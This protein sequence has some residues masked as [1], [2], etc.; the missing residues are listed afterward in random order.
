MKID[1]IGA[2]IGGLT[3]AIAFQKKGFTVRIFEQAKFLT[4]AGA[5]I[6]LASNAMQVFKHLNLN[7]DIQ[8]A[9]QTISSMNITKPNLRRLS[10]VSLADFENTY[11]VKNTAI[12]RGDLQ[13]ILLN[14]IDK[15][16]I[17]L[18]HTLKSIM[19]LEN[20]Q[21]LIFENGEEILSNI[22]IGADGIH[23]TV[24]KS[25]V[26]KAK[27]RWANQVCWRGIVNY[28]LPDQY[29]NQLNEA[30]GKGSRFGIVPLPDNRVYWYAL[31]TLK[32]GVVLNV[33][34]INTYFSEYAPLINNIIHE[35]KDTSIHEAEIT[36]LLPLDNWFN[37][38]ICLI[39]DAAH[40]MTPNMG[41]G[42]C[43]AIED[44][45]ILA[46]CLHKHPTKQA[47]ETYQKRRQSKVNFIVNTSWSVGKIGHLSNPLLITLRHIILKL[48]PN[49]VAKKQ[50]T[51]IFKL[52]KL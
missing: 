49:T 13:M 12:H 51:K 25:V 47:F 30:W 16:H 27:I 39:G 32:K 26:S 50:S 46:E 33:S 5:G 2:G 24:R 6:I 19:P 8:L 18:G 23:S 34:D 35:T 29:H 38:Q 15:K 3:A 36:D 40:A 20:G 21:K 41:Q 10:R 37:H 7:T 9:G 42:A 48:I 4:P 44:A 43:Q 31:K 1:I 28:S 52:S 22:L 45:Y 17:F 14:K 11:K